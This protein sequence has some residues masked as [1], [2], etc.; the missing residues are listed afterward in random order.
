MQS[1]PHSI[2]PEPTLTWWQRPQLG[3]AGDHSAPALV[4]LSI[5]IVSLM[6]LRERERERE[7][8]RASNCLHIDMRFTRLEFHIPPTAPVCLKR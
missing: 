4:S 3:G 8:V 1:Q 2:F 7:T 5:T 6:A